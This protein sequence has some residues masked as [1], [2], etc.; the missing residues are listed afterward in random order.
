L[1]NLEILR[2]H[3]KKKHSVPDKSGKFSCFWGEC[4]RTVQTIVEGGD[5]SR[6][7]QRFDFP[8]TTE[9]MEHVENKHI[10]PIAWELGDGPPGGFSGKFFAFLGGDIC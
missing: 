6:S 1:H 3:V 7:S 5:V 8:D 10:K 2:R 9:L 4:G